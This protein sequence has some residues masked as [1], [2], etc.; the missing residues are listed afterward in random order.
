MQ[1]I[2]EGS[3]C[4]NLGRPAS[5]QRGQ[6]ARNGGQDR[7]NKHESVKKRFDQEGIEIPFPYRNV[8]LKNEEK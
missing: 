4:R 7:W 8:V 6:D 5:R 3:I 2:V 1:K